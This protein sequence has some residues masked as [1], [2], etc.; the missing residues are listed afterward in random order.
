M[1]P[2]A[3]E[4]RM[5]EGGSGQAEIGYID[6]ASVLTDMASGNAGASLVRANC[7]Y[8][9]WRSFSWEQRTIAMLAV[10]LTWIEV[11]QVLEGGRG[12]GGY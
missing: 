10:H 1:Q 3:A 9:T 2:G 11:G 6:T 5:A 8:A 7:V 12:G 4:A